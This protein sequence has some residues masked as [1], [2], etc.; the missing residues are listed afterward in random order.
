MKF[1]IGSDS[2][3][4]LSGG[5]IT[6]ANPEGPPLKVARNSEKSLSSARTSDGIPAKAGVS[7]SELSPA[8]KLAANSGAIFRTKSIQP[9]TTNTIT[10]KPWRLIPGAVWTGA[11][12]GD[13]SRNTSVNSRAVASDSSEDG[14]GASCSEAASP[15][16]RQS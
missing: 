9:S 14:S 2:V 15:S 8:L 3:E 12:G 1:L 11:G 16:I 7:A 6:L 4:G 10:K 5:R 13:L